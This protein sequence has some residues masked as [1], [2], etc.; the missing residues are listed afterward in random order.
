MDL[1]KDNLKSRVGGISTTTVDLEGENVS[2]TTMQ[3]ALSRLENIG[4]V[5][6]S[7]SQTSNSYQFTVTFTSLL[8]EIPLF[9]VKMHQ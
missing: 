5:Q 2:E 9:L 3:E 4:Q 8:G 7:S 6:V 1:S